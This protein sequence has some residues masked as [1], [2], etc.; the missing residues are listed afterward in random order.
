M[1]KLSNATLIRTNQLYANQR[2]VIAHMVNKILCRLFFR[3]GWQ[4]III[5]LAI[6]LP[7]HPKNETL[8]HKCE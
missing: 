2:N 5:H 3:L 6:M 1:S 8:P 4:L 7:V